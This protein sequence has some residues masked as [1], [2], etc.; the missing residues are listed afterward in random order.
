MK[1][2]KLKVDVGVLGHFYSISYRLNNLAI[3]DLNRVGVFSKHLT[4]HI[5]KFYNSMISNN[6]A[7][8][9]HMTHIYKLCPISEP[10]FNQHDDVIKWVES[11]GNRSMVIEVRFQYKHA[12]QHN[13]V[14]KWA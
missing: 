10:F 5:P 9:S 11:L 3:A 14:M 13:D 1:T 4:S 2:C 12:K 6:R 7:G 8:L